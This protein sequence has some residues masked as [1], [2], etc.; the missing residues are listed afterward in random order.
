MRNLICAL[1]KELDFI[2]KTP[3]LLLI[4]FLAPL[5]YPFLYNY[6]YVNKFQ[7]DAPIVVCDLD[8]SERSRAF[9]RALDATQTVR[10]AGIQHD[11]ALCKTSVESNA[12]DGSIAIAE[13]FERDLLRHGRPVLRVYVNSTRFMPVGDIGKGVADAIANTSRDILVQ[14]FAARGIPREESGRYAAPI[15]MQVNNIANT[16]G[17]YGDFMI[18]AIL[19]LILQQTLF[20][21]CAVAAAGT[22][23]TARRSPPGTPVPVW[24]IG[25]AIPYFVLYCAYAVLFFTLH[26]RLW[27]IPF[28]GDVTVLSIIVI[29]QLS[30]VIAAGFL[31]GSFCRS[32]LTALML[33]IMSTY[34]V[35]LLSGIPWPVS[36][37]PGFFRII[38]SIL[39]ST[40]F[41]PAAFSAARLGAGFADVRHQMIA[42][43]LIG[44][45]I[46]PLLYLKMKLQTRDFR[47]N[48]YR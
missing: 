21:G 16:T 32:H 42:M 45:I 37:M 20:S 40:Y 10:V 23:R 14:S 31:M 7:T 2:A 26:Y 43:V 25:K 24:L 28:S 17:S 1:R 48:K 18:P 11:P 13:G 47:R 35:F 36:C 12:A 4:I 33:G 39:P 6:L 44:A 9:I 5:A 30:I 8:Q 27:R 34:P 29:M 19:L 38:S 46:L 41:I 15:V 3:A 22:R